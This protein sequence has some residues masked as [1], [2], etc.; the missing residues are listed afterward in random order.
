MSEHNQYVSKL[1]SKCQSTARYLT[2][3][4]DAHQA[5]AKHLLRE[6]ACALDGMAV[7]VRRKPW[8]RLMMINARGCQRLMTLRERLA[9]WLLGKKLEIRP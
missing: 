6:A 2:Y 3:N 9:Y 5:D 7:R 4:D 8:G 1:A